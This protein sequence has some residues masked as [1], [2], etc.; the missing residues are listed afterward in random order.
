MRIA[1]FASEARK[2]GDGRDQVVHHFYLALR[3]GLREV[4]PKPQTNEHWHP[5]DLLARHAFCFHSFKPG[6]EVIKNAAGVGL[7]DSADED[8]GHGA[9]VLRILTDEF[10]DAELA[11]VP[12]LG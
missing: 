9:D 7:K 10:A 8:V 2:I 3:Q 12:G 5:N 11:A 6:V 4:P 1:L